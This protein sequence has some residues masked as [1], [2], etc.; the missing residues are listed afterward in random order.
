MKYGGEV[1]TSLGRVIFHVY[2]QNEAKRISIGT[3]ALH[4]LY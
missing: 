2:I 4:L 1:H 3:R